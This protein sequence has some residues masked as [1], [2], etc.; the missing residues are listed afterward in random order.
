[1]QFIALKNLKKIE[2]FVNFFEPDVVLLENV[3]RVILL[4]VCYFL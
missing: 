3:E 4:R 1:M 2:E